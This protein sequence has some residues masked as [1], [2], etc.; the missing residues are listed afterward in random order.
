MTLV[1]DGIRVLE[2]AEYGFVPSAASVLGEWGADV[3]KVEHAS[4]ATPS[5]A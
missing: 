2:V 1:L 4:G 5:G 3:I